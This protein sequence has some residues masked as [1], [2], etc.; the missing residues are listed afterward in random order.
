V[1]FVA[2]AVYFAVSARRHPGRESVVLPD[3]RGARDDP[4]TSAAE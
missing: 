2:A 3:V 4:E 1:L